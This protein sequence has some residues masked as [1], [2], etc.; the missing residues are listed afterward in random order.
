MPRPIG[1]SDLDLKWKDSVAF[2]FQYHGYGTLRLGEMFPTL[3]N[4]PDIAVW[5]PMK[6]RGFVVECVSTDVC[7]S[8]SVPAHRVHRCRWLAENV[9]KIDC[10]PVAACRF[11]AGRDYTDI[12]IDLSGY[13]DRDIRVSRTGAVD[14]GEP[15]P[16][17]PRRAVMPWDGEEGVSA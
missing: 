14:A 2:M 6:D 5:L 9:P 1:C 8:V 7:S 17:E 10:I 4:A 11:G 12:Y 16:V 15:Q 13:P 3:P